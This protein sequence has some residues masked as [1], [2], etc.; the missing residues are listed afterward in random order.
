MQELPHFMSGEFFLI[1]E[2]WLGLIYLL[3]MAKND[4]LLVYY[5]LRVMFEFLISLVN[6][7]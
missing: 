4:F 2:K 3:E 1:D 6:C 7:Y 5:I